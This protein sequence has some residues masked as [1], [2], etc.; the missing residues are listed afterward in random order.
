MALSNE[1]TPGARSLFDLGG[2][3]RSWETGRNDADC[4]H[5][6]LG[7]VSN[8]PYNAA[9]LN[10]WRDHQPEGRKG[11]PALSSFE[12]R[13]KY[14]I[15]TKRFLESLGYEPK[16]ADLEFLETDKKYYETKPGS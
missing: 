12:V 14:L 9:P 4:L 10:N 7:R 13:S 8:S 15:K 6:I 16:K 11:L 5:H 1:F 3:M 2:Y